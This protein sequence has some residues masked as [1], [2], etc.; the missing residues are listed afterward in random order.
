MGIV[1]VCVGVIAYA[2]L[3][4][5]LIYRADR[6][7]ELQVNSRSFAGFHPAPAKYYPLIPG[8]FLAGLLIGAVLLLK[9]L[10]NGR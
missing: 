9:N 4:F 1:W 2:A 10:V 7:G 5:V 8:F 6:R 3:S